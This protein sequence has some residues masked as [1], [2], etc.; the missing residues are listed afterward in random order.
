MSS[1]NAF[2]FGKSKIMSSVHYYYQVSKCEK[3]GYGYMVTQVAATAPGMAA[4]KKT[5]E[6]IHLKIHLAKGGFKLK[7]RPKFKEAADDDGNVAIKGF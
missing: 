4:L 5:G 6:K 3:F 7:E 2:S 1:G